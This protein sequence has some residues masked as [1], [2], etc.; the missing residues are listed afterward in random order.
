MSEIRRVQLSGKSLTVSLP[1]EWSKEHNLNKGSYISLSKS[2][3]RGDKLILRK[4]PQED[5]SI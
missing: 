3:G 1:K 2:K 4:L 5:E